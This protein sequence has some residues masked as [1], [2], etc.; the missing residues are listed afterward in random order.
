[1]PGLSSPKTRRRSIEQASAAHSNSSSITSSPTCKAKQKQQQ[2]ILPRQDIHAP[3][4]GNGNRQ[5]ADPA[6]DH[7]EGARPEHL[8]AVLS[9]PRHGPEEPS[10]CLSQHQ[11]HPHH[12]PESSVGGYA[13]IPAQ[14]HQAPLASRPAED[15]QQQQLLDHQ[16]VPRD[17]Q[18]PQLAA[19]HLQ[20]Q[21][22]SQ[23]DQG[24]SASAQANSAHLQALIDT[25]LGPPKF[26]TP[27]PDAPRLSS[28]QEK[29]EAVGGRAL[30]DSS[31]VE[32]PHLQLEVLSGVAAGQVVKTSDVLQE[33][34][35]WEGS[36]G[37][38]LQVRGCCMGGQHQAFG[39][40]CWDA[41]RVVK[42]RAVCLRCKG[43]GPT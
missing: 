5:A 21:D 6:C 27:K 32:R 20:Q 1:M 2:D 40:T 30:G 25:E 3:G 23:A 22:E 15:Q 38:S 31:E 8:H 41:T 10:A 28:P 19:D 12:H 16:Y 17:A 43:Q 11:H 29:Q 37:S 4:W 14:V 7:W 42:A 9:P 39:P 18:E 35:F 36:H 24:R 26:S 34:G 13:S 33:V